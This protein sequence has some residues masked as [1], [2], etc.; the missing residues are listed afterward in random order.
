MSKYYSI[1]HLVGFLGAFVGFGGVAKKF[2]MIYPRIRLPNFGSEI[3]ENI[4][5]YALMK[6]YNKGCQQC[7]TGDFQM[8]DGKRIEVKCFSSDGPITFG[9]TETWDQLGLVDATRFEEGHFKVYLC[10]WSHDSPQFSN[11]KV[12]KKETMEIQRKAKRRPRISPKELFTQLGSE[13]ILIYEGN[14]LLS[15]APAKDITIDDKNKELKLKYLG[16]RSK[17]K[18]KELDGY[19]CLLGLSVTRAVKAVKIEMLDKFFDGI[20]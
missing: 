9:P 10:P 6:Y 1:D 13:M 20:K 2:K 7:K 12:S 18:V 4:C 14:N 3:S 11:F 8:E 17:L 5:R 16:E 15:L 19:L